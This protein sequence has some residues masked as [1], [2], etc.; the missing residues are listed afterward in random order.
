M[1]SNNW[2][3]IAVVFVVGVLLIIWHSRVD[4][5]S[6]VVTLVGIML[7]IPSL[8]NFI[9]QLSARKAGRESRGG[10]SAGLVTSIGCMALG[11]WM[12]ITPGFF[13]G[14]IAY[15][16]AALLILYGIY[17]ILVLA[18]WSRPFVMPGWFYIIPVLM[19]IAGVALLCT[20][21]RTLNNVVVLVTGI[22]LVAS[23]LNSILEYVGTHPG[24]RRETDA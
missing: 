15:V 2:F 23:A 5:L 9:R 4:I 17:H 3:T 12:V 22:A 21:V 20:S 24:E 18:V 6:W 14:V 19:I 11:I 16:F 10:E 8:Y 1:K 7:I 13:V